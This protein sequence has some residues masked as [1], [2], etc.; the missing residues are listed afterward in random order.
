MTV[1]PD[2]AGY[3]TRTGAAV[4][5]QL[6]LIGQ[7]TCGGCGTT[8][9]AVTEQLVDDD[10]DFVCTRATTNWTALVHAK[11]CEGEPE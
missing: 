11:T 6:H 4:T 1:A 2:G 5:T 8:E 10:Y 7:Y 9:T 3:L